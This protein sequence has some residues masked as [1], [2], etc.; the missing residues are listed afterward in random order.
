MSFFNEFSRKQ[1]LK[2]KFNKL[3][4]YI[5]FSKKKFKVMIETLY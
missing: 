5:L 2:I 3:Q 1:R 4:L